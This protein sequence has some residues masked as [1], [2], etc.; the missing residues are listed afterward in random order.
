VLPMTTGMAISLW[1]E[2]AGVLGFGV[3]GI[4]AMFPIGFMLVL[5][6]VLQRRTRND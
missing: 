3:V 6:I 4:I 2:Q 5:G 1:G